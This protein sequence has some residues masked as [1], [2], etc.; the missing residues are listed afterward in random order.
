MSLSDLK[1]AFRTVPTSRKTWLITIMQVTDP[2][3]GKVMFLVDKC[4]PFGASRS[5]VIYQAFSDC[6]AHLVGYLLGINP[7]SWSNYL[8]DF[9]FCAGSREEC[10]EM[11]SGFISLC[12]N[13]NIPLAEE[14]TI[15]PTQKLVFLGVLIDG[16]NEML[17]VSEEKKSKTINI[18]KKFW[19][20]RRQL[21]KKF[22]V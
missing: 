4:L 8:D 17:A 21:S 6:L 9:I 5:C 2:I 12:K 14:K 16:E 18:I 10:L 11:V 19:I 15:W 1:S 20:A 7:P 13:L 22:K 3:T